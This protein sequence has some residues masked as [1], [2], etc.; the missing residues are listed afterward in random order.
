MKAL[1]DYQAF[2]LQRYGGVSKCFC[3]LMAHFPEGYQYEIGVK[4]TAN[5]HLLNT[6]S[7]ASNIEKAKLTLD[8]FLGGINFRGKGRIYSFMNSWLPY[9][10]SSERI[11]KSYSLELIKR[12]DYDV[13]HPTFFDSYYLKY[14]D[15]KPFVFTIHDMMPELFPQYF[16][17]NDPQIVGK[18][19]LVDKAAAIVA[20]SDQTKQDIMRILGVDERKIHVVYHGSPQYKEEPIK[21]LVG[22][23]YYLYMG[24]RGCYKN[25]IP[26]LTDFAAYWKKGYTEKL[27]CTGPE[28]SVDELT[29]I[30]QLGVRDKV[31][32]Y[33]ASDSDVRSL[34]A[35]AVAFIY[36]SLYEGFGMPILEAFSC[37]CPVL[38]N[39]KSCFPEIAGDAALYF[40]SDGHNSDLTEVLENMTAF[41]MEKRNELIRK[42]YERNMLFSWTESARKLVDIYESVI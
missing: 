31:V 5:V 3:E 42:G 22:Y 24:T 10:P 25:F 35:Y 1:F 38:L 12:G 30:N 39:R 28:F 29:I 8:S 37:G 36:P 20:V 27:I 26:M 41:S 18:R 14:L 33:R 11:N 6:H 16:K 32:H 15:K 9:F 13:F 40:D 21:R 23:S 34:Y 2:T 4:S 17:R 7:I 19:Y